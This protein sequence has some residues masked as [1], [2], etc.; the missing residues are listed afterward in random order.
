V[1][2]CTLSLA[3][4]H[5]QL[6]ERKK[7]AAQQQ[8]NAER[9]AEYREAISTGE[10]TMEE[11]LQKAIDRE[12]EERAK[13]EAMA[14]TRQTWLKE[15]A[16]MLRWL[17]T[18]VSDKDDESLGWYT[19]PGSAGLFDHGI[20]ADAIEAGVTQLRRLQIHTFGR[21]TNG[22]EPGGGRRKVKAGGN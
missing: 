8:R 3:A 7:Q 21:H 11:A 17:Q 20:T 5:A 4:A 12:R 22:Q 14:D 16:G 2:A 15:L 9:V 18:F 6:A 13:T 19:Q 10:M 1:E